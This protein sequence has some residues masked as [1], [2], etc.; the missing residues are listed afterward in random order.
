MGWYNQLSK[1]EQMAIS[2]IPA[3]LHPEN[4]LTETADEP[5]AQH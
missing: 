2:A 4:D 1:E 5:V 3:E